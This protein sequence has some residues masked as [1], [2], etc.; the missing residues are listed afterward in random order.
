MR[1]LTC[2][3]NEQKLDGL[4]LSEAFQYWR[5]SLKRNRLKEV[6]DELVELMVLKSRPENEDMIREDK[7]TIIDSTGN[8]IN[9]VGFKIINDE[10]Y[11]T[12]HL[13]FIHGY[14]A[15]LG[16]FAR[17]F[18][19]INKFKNDKKFN[20]H[21][22][23][24]DNITFGLS[25]NP[26]IEYEGVNHWFI[27]QCPSLKIKDS[28]PNDKSNLYNKYYKLV[29]SFTIDRNEFS[30]YQEH[31]KPLLEEIE[32]FYIEAIENWRIASDI[33]QIDYLIGHSFGGYWSGS[34]SLKYPDNLK[35]LILLSPVGVERHVHSVTS[36]ILQEN[37]SEFVPD[38]DPTSYKFLSRVPILSN[39]HVRKWYYIL[40]FM[41]IFLKIF[42]PWGYRYYFNT[43]YR[44]LS[45][46][47]KVIDNLGGSEK[48][49]KS[50][51]DTVIGTKK[52]CLLIIEYL[53][54]SI[55]GGS[56]SDIYIKNL[57]TPATVSKWPLY[58]KFDA[59]YRSSKHDFKI[60]VLYGQ[61]DF[62]N[63]EAGE[64]MVQLI[65][66]NSSDQTTINFQKIKQ[67]GHNLYIDNPFD[68]NSAIHEIVTKGSVDSSH[69][70]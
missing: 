56:N 9:E 59:F 23:F 30:Q 58:D 22:H 6:Q 16:C 4:S 17:N 27:K 48:V 1:I 68:T 14:G 42:G 50:E 35:H 28:R 29:D 67:G 63:A 45:N 2:K 62:M 26:K 38:L 60:D 13:V 34:Y 7:Q 66:K 69:K 31:Y 3:R 43:W 64:K 21:I 61:F 52:E 24:L 53:Y 10:K 55:T 57:L 36:D 40:P 54:N 39:E 19:L 25:S 37:K 33:G 18:Q 5:Q 15:S 20:Y 65:R 8:H 44:K 51:N 41:P 46:I 11:Q 12:K 70:D 32:K 49:I 47:N